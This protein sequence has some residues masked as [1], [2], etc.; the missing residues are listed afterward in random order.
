MLFA[1][2][3]VDSKV[4]DHKGAKTIFD[5]NKNLIILPMNLD[6]IINN[7]I[8]VLRKWNYET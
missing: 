6:K 4:L 1:S 5:F 7:I 3:A 2:S 8:E